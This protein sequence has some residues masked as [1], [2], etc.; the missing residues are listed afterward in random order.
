MFL[1]AL[2]HLLVFNVEDQLVNLCSVLQVRVSVLHLTR[3]TAPQS[4]TQTSLWEP[5]LGCGLETS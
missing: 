5:S 3:L 4:W 1:L 2:Q